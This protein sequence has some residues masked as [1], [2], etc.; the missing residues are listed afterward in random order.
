ME[1]LE[2]KLVNE[3][4]TNEIFRKLIKESTGIEAVHDYYGMVEQTGSIY[5]ECEHGH[6][7]ALIF[8]K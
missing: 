1:G 2:K 3:A 6:L 7:H 4:V 8:Q 5:L